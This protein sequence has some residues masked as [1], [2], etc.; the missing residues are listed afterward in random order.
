MKQ[1]NSLPLLYSCSTS[2]FCALLCLDHQ[3]SVW[4]TCLNTSILCL[5]LMIFLKDCHPQNNWALE[6]AFIIY[7]PPIWVKSWV[8][9]HLGFLSAGGGGG[10][11]SH[12]RS[13]IPFHAISR[14]SSF[15]KSGIGGILGGGKKIVLNVWKSLCQQIYWWDP[16][17]CLNRA[18][19]FLIF[20]WQESY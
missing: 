10:D 9:P 4:L 16:G 6:N 2:V 7:F 3:C 5:C 18:S 13:L 14:V 15:S 8:G 19:I 20:I 12:S 1:G 11:F 17:H